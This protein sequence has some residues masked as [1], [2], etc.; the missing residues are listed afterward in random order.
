[1]D[2]S[3]QRPS[4]RHA[5]LGPAFFGPVTPARFPQTILRYR[6]QA[7]AE[8]RGAPDRLVAA[9]WRFLAETRAPFERFLF[10]WYGGHASATRARA[11]LCPPAQTRTRPSPV[12]AVLEPVASARLDHPYFAEAPCTLPI[13]AVAALWAPIA[14]ADD[15]SL[16]AA[17][18]AGVARMA[19]ACGTAPASA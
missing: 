3:A 4:R 10:D 17:E 12:R 11:G 14:A 8:R 7:W 15:G 19:G 18:L 13:D 2:D 5:D 9:V 6:N 1:M 16:F